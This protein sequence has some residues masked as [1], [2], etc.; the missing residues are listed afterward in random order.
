M[1]LDEIPRLLEHTFFMWRRLKILCCCRSLASDDLGRLKQG[2]PL[3]EA[4]CRPM[5]LYEVEELTHGLSR[6]EKLGLLSEF[7]S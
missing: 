6:A 5:F 4:H 7:W 3:L 1:P 2:G